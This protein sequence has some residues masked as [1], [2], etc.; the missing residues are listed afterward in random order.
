[1]QLIINNAIK[2]LDVPKYSNM[3]YMNFV[4][5]ITKMYID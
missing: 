3:H 5:E 4:D 1:M 2:L